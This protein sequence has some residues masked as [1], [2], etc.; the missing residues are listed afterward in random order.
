LAICLVV[1]GCEREKLIKSRFVLE[2]E[3]KDL[4][5]R[6]VFDSPIF[7]HNL[8]SYRRT[9]PSRS[10]PIAV[11]PVNLSTRFVSALGDYIDAGV[12]EASTLLGHFFDMFMKDCQLLESFEVDNFVLRNASVLSKW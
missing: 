8:T 9:V 11:D 6:C 1:A 4:P 7:S 3:V 12:E 5:S 10:A 2:S